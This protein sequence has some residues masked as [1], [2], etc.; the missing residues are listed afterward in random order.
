MGILA[1]SPQH[2]CASVTV[3]ERAVEGYDLDEPIARGYG[4]WRRLAPFKRREF[5]S[6]HETAL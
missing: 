3:A 4:V 5:L 6:V 1:H 2:D